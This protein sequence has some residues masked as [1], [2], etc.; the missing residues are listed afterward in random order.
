MAQIL[1]RDLEPWVVEKLKE[2]AARNGRSL[3][4]HLRMI[5]EEESWIPASAARAEAPAA[6][7][8]KRASRPCSRGRRK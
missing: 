8:R 3:E 7:S 5:I 2:Q 6:P 4:A 1:I